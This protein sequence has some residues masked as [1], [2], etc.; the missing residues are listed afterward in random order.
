MDQIEI[1]LSER[2][3]KLFLVVGE[4][5]PTHLFPNPNP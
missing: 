2:Y 4:H 1:H 5:H 3:G